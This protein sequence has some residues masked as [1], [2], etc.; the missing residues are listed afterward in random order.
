MELVALEPCLAYRIPLE[1]DLLTCETC[2]Y[3]IEEHEP[4]LAR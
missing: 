4:D 3:W 2:G 1:G